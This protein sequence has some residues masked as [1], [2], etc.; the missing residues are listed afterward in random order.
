V[1]IGTPDE[2][3]RELWQGIRLEVE[4]GGCDP[5][6]ISLPPAAREVTWDAAEGL[7]SLWIPQRGAI[8]DLVASLV[9][10]GCRVF[11]VS[12]QEPTL[13]D[14]YFALHEQARRGV[15]A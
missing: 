14:V 1:A 11:R 10:A 5:T 8:P 9:G 12:P 3:A 2:L 6:A 13:E 7:L 4:L 15:S